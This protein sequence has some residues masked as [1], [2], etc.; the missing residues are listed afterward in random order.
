[1][2]EQSVIEWSICWFQERKFECLLAWF[3]IWKRSLA[4][5]QTQ[6]TAQ[7]HSQTT[8]QSHRQTTAKSD[9]P[10]HSYTT[11]TDHSTAWRQNSGTDR[12]QQSQT[13]TTAQLHNTDRPQHSQ[14]DG[15][16]EEDGNNYKYR[17][18]GSI[19]CAK[20]RWIII[21]EVP[22]WLNSLQ[23]VVQSP[24]CGPIPSP[25]LAAQSPFPSLQP[26]LQS[27]LAGQ[28]PACGPVPSF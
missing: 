17:S 5:D 20:D 9:G 27:Q 6:T 7:L 12:P 3:V 16:T 23:L 14:T 11:Q 26:R 4:D 25:Q 1:M 19:N 24:A 21:Y 8:A 18:K 2:G 22:S 15:K 28:S 13:D 10:Q